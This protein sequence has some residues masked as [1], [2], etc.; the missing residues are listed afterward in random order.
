MRVTAFVMFVF[1][2]VRQQRWLEQVIVEISPFQS[3]TS[4]VRINETLNSAGPW[5]K[6]GYV[7]EFDGVILDFHAGLRWV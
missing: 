4:L 6:A 1:A 3:D 5:C 2:D 7:S